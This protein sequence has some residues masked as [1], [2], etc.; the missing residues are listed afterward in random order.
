MTDDELAF[1]RAATAQP[2]DDTIRL[3]YADWLEEQGGEKFAAQAAFVRLQVSRCRLDLFD[4]ERAPLVRQE[5][6]LAQ[7][8]RRGWNGRVHQHLMHAGA[9][10]QV[11]VRR[12]IIRS[13]E[14]H[15]GMVER[16]TV[17][18]G[19][20]ASHADLALSIGPIQ[21]LAVAG[22]GTTTANLRAALS[23]LLPKLKALALSG[24]PSHTTLIDLARIEGLGLL[25]L[26]DLRS[27]DCGRRADELYSLAREGR[28]SPVVLFRRAVLAAA[29]FTAYRRTY[30]TQTSRDELHVIDPFG[31]WDEH[32][33][34]YSDLSGTA[35]TPVVYSVPGR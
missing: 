19:G 26:L 12:G 1:I 32:R 29:P 18:A 31:H 10:E 13:W 7:R 34:W 3:V 28:I 25:P 35:L 15:R 2:D 33:R 14:Y 5:G 17:A 8:H 23:R 22:W 21:C 6:E 4:P 9:R 16:V 27:L 30:T 11:S 20:L 24:S